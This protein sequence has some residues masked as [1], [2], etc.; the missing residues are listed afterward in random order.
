MLFVLR[1]ICGHSAEAAS[2]VISGRGLDVLVS[3]LEDFE[4]SVREGAAWAVGYTAR[5]SQ[6]LAQSVMDAGVVP[7]LVLLLREPELSGKQVAASALRDVARHSPDL[8]QSVVD[9]GA[10]PHLVRC[11]RSEKDEKLKRQALDALGAVAT[12]TV[13]LAEVVVEAEIFPEALI[14]MGHA[15]GRVREAAACLVRDVVKHSLGLAQLIVDVGGLGAI[16]EFMAAS[17][18]KSARQVYG[19]DGLVEC[20]TASGYIA[21]KPH[22]R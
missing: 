14:H 20:I 4:P 18:R 16:V 6:Q 10:V 19:D 12:H 3:C 13:D 1:S 11:V 8:A 9:S 15:C 2:S 5:H 22:K 21:G 7:L 17:A